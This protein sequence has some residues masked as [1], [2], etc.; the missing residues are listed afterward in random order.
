MSELQEQPQLSATQ[1]PPPHGLVHKP[2]AEVSVD[3]RENK[4]RSRQSS[5]RLR[6]H[7]PDLDLQEQPQLPA[8]QRLPLRGLL[9]KQCA[10]ESFLPADNLGSHRYGHPWTTYICPRFKSSTSCQQRSDHLC[11]TSFAST[12]QRSASF[13]EKF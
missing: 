9:D 8:T 13:L 1:R 6:L 4:T 5:H 2:S 3:T 12:V 11:V 10:E 7:S